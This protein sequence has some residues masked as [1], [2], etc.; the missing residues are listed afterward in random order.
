MNRCFGIGAGILFLAAATGF[1]AQTFVAFGLTNVT[2]GNAA[3]VLHPSDTSR[4]N[5]IGTN[6]DDG[7][8]IFLGE[9]DSGVFVYP[10]TYD[11]PYYGSFM[12]GKLYG[13]VNGET[14][15]LISSVRGHKESYGYH[16]VQIDFG[17]LGST[18][19]TY[20][21]FR[22][23]SLVAQT[24]PHEG[25]MAVYG[26]YFDPYY[27]RVNPFWRMPDGSV[28]AIIEFDTHAPMSLPGLGDVRGDRVFI[29]AENPT[30][31]VDYASRLDVTGGGQLFW[32]EIYGARLGM[33]RHAHL[34]LADTLLQA[35]ERTL[36]LAHDGTNT[37][38]PGVIIE[39]DLATAFDLAFLPIELE[40]NAT[41]TMTAAGFGSAPG[42]GFGSAR[43]AHTG[44][45]LELSAA[46]DF[47]TCSN[48][49]S[50]VYNNGVQVARADGTNVLVPASARLTGATLVARSQKG[51]P[52]FSLYLDQ[53]VP[54]TLPNLMTYGGNEIRFVACSDAKF[55]ALQ[56]LALEATGLSSFTISNESSQPL[57]RP[58]LDIARAGT[59]VELSWI[60]YNRLYRV[61]ATDYL[62]SEA[63]FNG[64][65]AEPTY[66]GDVARVLFEVDPGI[67]GAQFFRLVLPEEED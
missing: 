25:T 14:N 53:S 38:G 34:A 7:V 37:T 31:V 16:P 15:R 64:Q 46:F 28:G 63:C 11:D 41:F 47:A 39:L 52:V 24:G 9:A 8:S 32:F 51:P 48:T 33:F 56:S 55:L 60:D 67:S 26:N 36:T 62:D 54:V 27:P 30:N 45:A 10:S 50:V 6:G 23:S 59:H 17:P 49:E 21:L 65:S 3:Y 44:S 13:S 22:G 57:E 58:R 40:T 2:L 12:L 35:R 4:F 61:Q 5:N 19:F 42:E 66:T 29:R 20:Q 1:G 43:V 18:H